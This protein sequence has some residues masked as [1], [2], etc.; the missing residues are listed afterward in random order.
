MQR[1]FGLF[2]LILMVMLPILIGRALY[3]DLQHPEWWVDWNHDPRVYLTYGAVVF[4]IPVFVLV[5]HRW[6][7]ARIK[8][9]LNKILSEV[10]RKREQGQHQEADRLLDEFERIFTKCYGGPPASFL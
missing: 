2:G 5:R 9:R 10:D 6:E 8:K 1:L 4:S 3:Q 7:Q